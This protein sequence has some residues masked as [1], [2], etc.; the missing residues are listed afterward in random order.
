[1]IAERLT[2]RTDSLCKRSR[3]AACRTGRSRAAHGGARRPAP[4]KPRRRE[5]ARSPAP[6]ST[7]CSVWGRQHSGGR[8]RARLAGEFGRDERLRAAGGEA[9]RGG[10]G[11]GRGA[12]AGAA[13]VRLALAGTPSRRRP[14]SC[15]AQVVPLAVWVPHGA[16]SGGL[17]GVAAWGRPPPPLPPPRPRTFAACPTALPRSRGK[18]REERRK[19]SKSRERKRSRSKSR[20]RKRRSKSRERRRR[21]AVFSVVLAW[22]ARAC[23]FSSGG[24]MH[25]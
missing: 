4:I 1:M 22:W 5:R 19:R 2:E 24:E 20:D 3:Q 16:R 11:S 14:A 10:R 6:L 7:C 21:C 25:C 13:Q 9:R 17:C 23:A 12:T 18:D 8:R 15:C